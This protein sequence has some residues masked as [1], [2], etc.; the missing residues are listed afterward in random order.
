MFQFV[1]NKIFVFSTTANLFGAE[2]NVAEIQ[3]ALKISPFVKNFAVTNTL[4]YCTTMAKRE[5]VYNITK[6]NFSQ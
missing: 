1:L 3:Q 4:A 2:V 6:R 5:I